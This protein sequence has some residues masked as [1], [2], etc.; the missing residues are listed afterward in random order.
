MSCHAIVCC[1]FRLDVV[2][3]RLSR[4]LQHGLF[5]NF[6]ALSSVVN[7]SVFTVTS[8]NILSHDSFQCSPLSL[9]PLQRA[10]LHQQTVN[11]STSPV[12]RI[13]PFFLE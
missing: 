3:H 5:T 13:N 9:V 10:V 1:D 6:S 11:G 2:A 12:V 8:S 4:D 7:H